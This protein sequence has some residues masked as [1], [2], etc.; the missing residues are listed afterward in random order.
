MFLLLELILIRA[1]QQAEDHRWVYSLKGFLNKK[2][3]KIRIPL[4]I[5]GEVRN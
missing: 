2:E 1:E 4:L 3:S 5:I